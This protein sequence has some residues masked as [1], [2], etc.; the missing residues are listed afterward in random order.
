[1][2]HQCLRF[3]QL[4]KQMRVLD[5]LEPHN[6]TYQNKVQLA[7]KSCFLLIFLFHDAIIQCED[8]L[9]QPLHHL[10]P[11]LTLRHHEQQDAEDQS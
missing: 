10:I 5:S 9:S 6:P 2:E 8:Q 3:F 1:M 11:K 7:Y 4:P